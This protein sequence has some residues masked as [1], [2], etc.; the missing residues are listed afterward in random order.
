[1]TKFT[2]FIEHTLFNKLK[3][4]QSR[5]GK[6]KFRPGT[7][8]RS[9]TTNIDSN[10]TRVYKPWTKTSLWTFLSFSVYLFFIFLITLPV[11]MLTT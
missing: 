10:N 8:L 1:M 4:I 5:P 2:H 6:F 3:T 7:G 9:S 11:L